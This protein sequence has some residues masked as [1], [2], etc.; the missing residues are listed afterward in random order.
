MILQN[1]TKVWKFH[2]KGQ[3]LQLSL[4]FCI[5]Q[6]T[7][8]P[9]YLLHSDCNHICALSA[10]IKICHHVFMVQQA[11]N[12]YLAPIIHSKLDYCNSPHYKLPKTRLSGLQQIQNSLACTVLGPVLSWT[13]PL[14]ESRELV[15]FIRRY[16]CSATFIILSKNN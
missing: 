6:K 12:I 3:I 7:V 15:L 5:P 13:C 2:G 10:S 1:S 16:S 8:C 11:C 4:K 14:K 9:N